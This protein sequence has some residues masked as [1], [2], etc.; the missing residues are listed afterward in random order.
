MQQ[1]CLLFFFFKLQLFVCMCEIIYSLTNS[2]NISTEVFEIFLV[3]TFGFYKHIKHNPK[4]Q[5]VN[6]FLV[7]Y[8]VCLF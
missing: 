1:T 4:N 8:L 2:Y 5:K 3:S 6:Y 7:P